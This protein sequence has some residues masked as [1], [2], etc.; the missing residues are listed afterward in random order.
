MTAN[1]FRKL[2]L[3]FPGA[4]EAEHMNHPDFRA[5]G[6]IFATLDYPDKNS[7]MVKL[8]PSQQSSFI[9]K[10]PEAFQPCSGVWGQRGAT[11]VHLP[12]ATRRVL[13]AALD[14]AWKNVTLDS[15]KEVGS[16]RVAANRKI[17]AGASSR[18]RS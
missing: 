11:H 4:T 10:P 14:A 8:T 13:R 12:S 5:G 3:G 18:R 9:R 1:E 7:G 6:K 17:H 15:S 2:A 16:A